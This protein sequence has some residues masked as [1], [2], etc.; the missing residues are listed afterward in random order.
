M[1]QT[2]ADAQVSQDDMTDPE[3]AARSS[4]TGG[5]T[6]PPDAKRERDTLAQQGRELA[7]ERRRREQAEQ[8]LTTFSQRQAAL[9]RQV[10][11]LT[12]SM[13][14]QR[15]AEQETRLAS[16][17]PIERAEARA[18]IAEDKADHAA[19]LAT[20]RD[21]SS[22]TPQQYQARRSRELID[23]INTTHGL[24]GDLALTG[25]EEE[26][27]WEDERGFSA[28][29]RVLARV[30]QKQIG[31][32]RNGDETMAQK[33]AAPSVEDIATQAVEAA[34]RN[35]GIEVGRPISPRPT[36]GESGGVSEIDFQR[37]HDRYSS[38][39]GPHK[40]KLA[41]RELRDRAIEQAARMQR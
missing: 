12:S 35:V 41:L 1:Q 19:R 15:Q 6:S 21:T 36:G 32:A 40:T 38:K 39:Q 28:S 10:Q 2:Y 4:D 23:E 3:T 17:P 29:A 9:E 24:G 20:R 16:L 13:V 18:K 27:D 7:A 33:Q 14:A 11:G 26:L 37:I 25:R 8:Q 34:L 22:E 5:D 30:R 31:T